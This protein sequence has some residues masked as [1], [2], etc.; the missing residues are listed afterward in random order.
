MKKYFSILLLLP[1][2]TTDLVAA[3]I[4]ADIS[5]GYTYDDNVTR[6]ELD[7]DIEADSILNLDISGSYKLPVNQSS[8]FSLQGTIKANQYADF[9]KLNNT[10]LGIH[11]SYHIRPSTGYTAISYFARLAYEQRLYKSEQRDGSATEIE[12]GLSKRLTDLLAMRFGYIKQDISAESKV[13]DADDSRFY[14]DIDYK[15]GKKNLLY[16]TISL[17]DGDVVSTAVPTQD[18]I[19]ASSA[20]VRDDAFLDLTPARFAYKLDAKTTTIRL[21]NNYTISSDQSIDA[22]VLY[23]KSETDYYNQ[24]TLRD[25]NIDYSGLIFNLNYLHRF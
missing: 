6:A 22:S 23:Y 9:N 18:I 17:I 7:S 12:V 21:G 11:G 4:K 20:I 15:I 10:R 13:F 1:F 8:Y 24:A 25:I 2:C 16:T 3:P 5:L 19:N 14:F